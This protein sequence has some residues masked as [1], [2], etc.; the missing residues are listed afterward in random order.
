ML[1]QIVIMGRLTRDPELRSTQSGVAVTTFRVAVDRDRQPKE[2][3]RVTDFF[4]VTCWRQR[5]EFVTKYFKK[6]QMITIKGRMESYNWTDKEG[7]KRTSWELQAEDVYFA[8]GKSGDA[9][10]S[11]A[12]QDEHDEGAQQPQP[13]SD[14]PPFPDLDEGELPF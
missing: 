9:A 5:A 1:N 14:M 12:D 3:E 4:T 6:G 7:S 11:T 13:Q 8:G 10:A 2:G